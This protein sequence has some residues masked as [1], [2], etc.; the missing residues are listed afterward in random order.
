MVLFIQR[1]AFRKAVLW[2]RRNVAQ[3][4][5]EEHRRSAG[6]DV[7]GEGMKRSRLGRGELRSRPVGLAQGGSDQAGLRSSSRISVAALSPTARRRCWMISL[8][9]AA[10]R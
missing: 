9:R 7:T 6:G 10:A 8:S 5:V 4:A 1:L 2:A 3:Q